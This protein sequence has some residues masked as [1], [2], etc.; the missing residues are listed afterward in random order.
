MRPITPEEYSELLNWIKEHCWFYVFPL[1]DYKRVKYIESSYDT[2]TGDIWQI[3]M[4]EFNFW[5]R[6]DNENDW[7]TITD[8]IKEFLTK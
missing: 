8:W 4:H 7:K 6:D 2:R 1:N 5:V 3:G